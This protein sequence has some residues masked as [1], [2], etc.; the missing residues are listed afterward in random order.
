MLLLKTSLG[1]KLEI[2]VTQRLSRDQKRGVRMLLML[3]DDEDR[4][5][6]FTATLNVIDP[7]M[8]LV[9]WRNARKMVREVEP[10][11]PFE[12]DR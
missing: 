5:R 7:A 11:Q 4:I 10:Y 9:I 6:G 12:G 3:E 2:R 1:L 8:R